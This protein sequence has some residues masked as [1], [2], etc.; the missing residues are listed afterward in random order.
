MLAILRASSPDASE[1]PT[2]RTASRRASAQIQVQPVQQTYW[3]EYDDGS[4]AENEPY[5]IYVDPDSEATFPGAKTVAYVISKAKKPIQKVKSWWSPNVSAGERQPLLRNNGNFAPQS[6]TTD[7]E[8]DDE[9]YASS[10]DFPGGYATHYA[11]FPSVKD[12]KLSLYREKLLFRSTIGGFSAAAMLLLISGILLGAG[13]HR[14][15]VEVDAG[16]T[17]GIV[18][19]LLFASMAFGCMLYQKE[20]LGWLYRVCVGITFVAI[21]VLN[22]M[23]LVLVAGNTGL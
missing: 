1:P 23:M 2:P 14:F 22:G 18:A 21:C 3:N 6:P 4:E 13:R 9:A 20:R 5:I 16:V 19:S 10:S 11:T 8:A 15:R 7:T 17:V 12:Q